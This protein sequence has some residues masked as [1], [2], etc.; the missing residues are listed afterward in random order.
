MLTDRVF[1]MSLSAGN[2]AP[3]HSQGRT[4]HLDIHCPVPPT[5]RASSLERRTLELVVMSVWTVGCFKCILQPLVDVLFNL[6]CAAIDLQKLNSC[7]WHQQ[8][9]VNNVLK[10]RAISD[11]QMSRESLIA[12]TCND[13]SISNPAPPI[14][15]CFHSSASSK[16]F[17]K[18]TNLWRPFKRSIAVCVLH[19]CDR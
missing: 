19:N 11:I 3:H 13:W 1:G 8:A 10:T 18:W 6:P 14:Q 4:L 9:L 5:E 7:P 16:R 12:R 15:E 2:Q 17:V